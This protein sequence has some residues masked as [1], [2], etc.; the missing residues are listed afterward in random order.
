MASRTSPFRSAT[1]VSNALRH[2]RGQRPAACPLRCEQLGTAGLASALAQETWSTRRPRAGGQ[3]LDCIP[4]RL[5]VPAQSPTR[6]SCAT[7]RRFYVKTWGR[8]AHSRAIGFPVLAIVTFHCGDADLHGLGDLGLGHV[9]AE[10]HVRSTAITTERSMSAIA[11]CSALGMT[12]GGLGAMR[13][14][15]TACLKAM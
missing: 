7:G 15:T 5:H 14:T 8:T 6:A 9:A 3:Q 13:S 10:P 11:P 1:V 4:A 12:R 2:A